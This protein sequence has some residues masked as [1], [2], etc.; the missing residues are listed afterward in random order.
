MTMIEIYLKNAEHPFIHVESHAVP[1]KG[2]M[3]NI[4][5]QTYTVERVTWAVD[6]ADCTRKMRANVQVRLATEQR[7]P[8]KRRGRS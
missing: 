2:E 8:I 6:Q 1:R 4:A 5:R 3:I 7:T